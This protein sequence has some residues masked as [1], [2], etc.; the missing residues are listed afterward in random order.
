MSIKQTMQ[1]DQ[2]MQ[3]KGITVPT[4]NKTKKELFGTTSKALLTDRMLI[5][6]SITAMFF[7]HFDLIWFLILHLVVPIQS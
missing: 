4:R 1:N 5:L 3:H 6:W 2:Y 7:E